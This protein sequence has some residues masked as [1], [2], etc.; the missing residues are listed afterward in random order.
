MNIFVSFAYKDE[1][2]AHRLKADLAK[3]G[4]SCWI[5]QSEILPGDVVPERIEQAIRSTD[6]LLAICSQASTGRE[7][8]EQEILCAKSLNI[9]IV[10]VLIEECA[11]PIHLNRIHAPKLFPSYQQG[12]GEIL[13]L[14]SRDRPIPDAT[15]PLECPFPGLSAFLEKQSHL[16]FGRERE[17][18][19][20]TQKL[21]QDALT[22]LLITGPSG[23]GKS[24]LA[25]AGL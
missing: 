2:V 17:Q 23:S 24:S 15:L 13:N 19:I 4:H 9:K 1:H 8:P 3:A 22:F 20:I 11:L 18:A 7:W 21:S 16:F 12:Q 6:M 5:D 10:P 25:Q 14:L